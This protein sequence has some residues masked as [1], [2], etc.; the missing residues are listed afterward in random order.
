MK[1]WLCIFLIFSL[2]G[3]GTTRTTSKSKENIKLVDRGVVERSAPGERVYITIPA[4]PN[5]RPKNETKTFSGEKGS[6]TDVDF[7]K[8][9]N[10]TKIV[11]D[12]PEV[13]EREAK[14]LELDYSKKE[15]DSERQFNI[16][17]AKI[18]QSTILWLGGIFAVAWVVKG[19]FTK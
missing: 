4:T 11:T 13:N 3:C 5:E 18:G 1:K 2:A 9:G 7:D 17:L 14:N 6:R 8:D 16:E 15:K 19:I 10:V 12:C